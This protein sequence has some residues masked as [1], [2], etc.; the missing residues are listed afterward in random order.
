MALEFY[1]GI[2]GLHL[3]LSRSK[4]LSQVIRAFDW[5]QSAC[6][7]YEANYGPG[8]VKKVSA[9]LSLFFLVL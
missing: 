4:Y 8:I 6:S 3:A 2:G 1:S 9:Q 7:V 5:D